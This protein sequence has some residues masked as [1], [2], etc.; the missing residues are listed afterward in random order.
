M[1]KYHTTKQACKTLKQGGI[2][3]F[4][5]DTVYGIGCRMDNVDAV[6]RLNKLLKRPSTQPLPV[7]VDSVEMGRKYFQPLSDAV[8]RLIQRYWPGGLTVVYY[9][10]TELVPQDVRG[11]GKTLGVRMPDYE[12]MVQLIDKI[13]V[14]LVGTSANFHGAETP[15]SFAD[16]DQRLMQMVD[17]IIAGECKLNQA[18]TV[19][20]CTVKPWKILRQGVVKL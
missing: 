11:G 10:K 9:C 7:L 6:K 17:A 16:L 12:T 1:D 19:V 20:D 15:C 14:P 18:S 8:Y 4:P 5:T 3:I 2:V 13:G